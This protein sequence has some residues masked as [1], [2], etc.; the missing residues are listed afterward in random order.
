VS[1][2]EAFGLPLLTLFIQVAG[3]ASAEAFGHTLVVYL[4]SPTGE[5][6]AVLCDDELLATLAAS[7]MVAAIP[8]AFASSLRVDEVEITSTSD[9]TVSLASSFGVTLG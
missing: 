1:S 5:L 2:A 9:V 8:D 7:E 4:I 3:I 6:V